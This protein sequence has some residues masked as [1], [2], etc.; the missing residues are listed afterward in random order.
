MPDLG[1]LAAYELGV[2]LER[3]AL[4]PE[5]G[6]DWPQVVAALLDGIDVVVVAPPAV[7][8]AV[9]ARFSSPTAS[10]RRPADHRG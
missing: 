9:S 3:L 1:L 2:D 10:G 6:P 4:V 5:P 8:P 7:T